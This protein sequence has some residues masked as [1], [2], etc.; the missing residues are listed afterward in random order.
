SERAISKMLFVLTN[1]WG[2]LLSPHLK[3][4]Q[5]SS[6]VVE[7]L[8]SLYEILGA[9]KIDDIVFTSSGAEAVNHVIQSV[10]YDQTLESGKNHLITSNIDEAP[11]IMA[12]G[13]LE[14]INCMGKMVDANK[15]GVITAQAIAD[16][17]SPRTAMVSLSWANGLTG[18]IN[19]VHEIG[20][21]C[22]ERGSCFHLDATHVLGKLYFD[23]EDT[24]A[25]H[26]TFNGDHLHA[27]KGTGGL[28]V[29][30]G[31]RLSPFIVGGIEQAGL[32]AGSFSTA[33]LAALGEAAKEALDARDFVCTEVARLRDKLEDGIVSNFPDAVPFF[34]NQ[35]RLPHITAIAFPGMTNESL[36][37]QLSRS[38]V[39]ACIGGG[40]F[41][42]IGIVLENSGVDHHLAHSAISFSLSRETSEEEIDQAIAIIVGEAKK[43]SKLSTCF[44]KK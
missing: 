3:G 32:R 33:N 2:N 37:Y 4:H 18:V 31:R 21:L 36:L 11:G 35:E 30:G 28:W 24:G 12:I 16:A 23:L 34:Q 27:P 42:Q 6:E 10:Y 22:E 41:Q 17:M 26:V 44:Y 38:G 14:E 9:K 25:T 8:N 13:R 20:K 7:A 40:S 1:K 43:L 29:R 15:D 5:V 39:Y 19:P